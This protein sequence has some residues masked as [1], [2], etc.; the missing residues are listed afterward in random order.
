MP[1]VENEDTLLLG[2][3]LNHLEG[4]HLVHPCDQCLHPV[5][6]VDPVVDSSATLTV[7]E[8][9]WEPKHHSEVDE[10]QH[11]HCVANGAHRGVFN[12]M[13]AFCVELKAESH[14]LR[15]DERFPDPD[16]KD[17]LVPTLD[18]DVMVIFHFHQLF[19][20]VPPRL[21]V[22]RLLVLLSQFIEF[23]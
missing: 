6:E 7:D 13:E 21:A 19:R 9:R 12:M 2:P 11:V 10:G 8:N 14:V 5:E 22:S 3:P 20:Y 4:G 23:F 17:Y 16:G 15:M 1:S 18:L